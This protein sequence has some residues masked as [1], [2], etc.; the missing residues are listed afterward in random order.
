[1]PRFIG[2]PKI[3]K[4]DKLV[5]FEVSCESR[6]QPEI[7][8]SFNSKKIENQGRYFS[9][10]IKQQSLY[11]IVLELDS[12]QPSDAG[13]YRLIAKNQN[14]SSEISVNFKQ[15]DEKKK[16]EEKKPEQKS[17]VEAEAKENKNDQNKAGISPNTKS[18]PA[19]FKD[20]PK[21]QVCLIYFL[22]K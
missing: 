2:A 17:K 21:D 16:P 6:D 20:K 8:W 12:P 7:Y 3:L 14:G 15:E 5:V 22:Q 1:V 4:E 19:T 11:K 10:V 9:E 13:I 18:A